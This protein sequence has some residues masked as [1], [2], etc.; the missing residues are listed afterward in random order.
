MLNF[1]PQGL[2]PF[3]IWDLHLNKFKFKYPND[4]ATQLLQHFYTSPWGPKFNI[5]QSALWKIK[6][7][8]IFLKTGNENAS[9]NGMNCQFDKHI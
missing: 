7:N 1:E 8:Y 2:V 6:I 3:R 9:I 5:V 4:V